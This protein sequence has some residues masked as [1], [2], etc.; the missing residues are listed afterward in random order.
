[1]LR[2]HDRR[3]R[4]G[5]LQ[6]PAGRRPSLVSRCTVLGFATALVLIGLAFSPAVAAASAP[7]GTLT[8]NVVVIGAPA[9]FAGEVG[10]AV[11]PVSSSKG[12]CT[13][14]QYAV[15]GS[16]GSYTLSLAA[17]PWQVREFYS[18]GFEGGAFLGRPRT[19]SLVGGQTIRENISIRYRVPSSLV[20]TVTV[21]GV[22]SG[23]SVEQLS[24]IAC[25]SSSPVVDGVPSLLCA[26]DFLDPGSSDFSLPT[27]SKG[28]WLLYVGYYTEFGLTTVAVPGAVS[29]AKGAS[30]TD[31]VSVAYQTP[32]NALVEGTV[33]VSGAPADFSALVGVGGCP[34]TDGPSRASR[35]GATACASPD[36][37]LA[38][39]GGSY[40]LVVPQGQWGFA[41]FYELAP[42]GGQF[43]SA[44]QTTTL[45]GGSILTLNF[46]V[47]YEAPASV[48]SLIDVKGVPAGTTVEETLLLA[49]PTIAPYAGGTV[50]IECVS[51]GVNPGQVATIATLPPGK[52][53]LYPGYATATSEAIG[54]KAKRVTLAS[55]Q[56][57]VKNL[58]IDYSS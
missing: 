13:S 31:D 50:P 58:T 11:C 23:V 6:I 49:C 2:V 20:G 38:G 44:I 51:A 4:S 25:P 56:S 33:T 28:T 15:S 22:P 29:L 55:G 42:F 45:T 47:P 52:W 40:Q 36:Y 14:P 37:T 21:T 7:N 17:G 57:A 12:L 30:L 3:R 24:L 35:G 34:T 27:L 32:T 8:G 26:T 43:L 9:G 48:S 10:V 54:T 39:S 18:V 5:A 46:T 53:L 19:L 41:G 16:G 1:M